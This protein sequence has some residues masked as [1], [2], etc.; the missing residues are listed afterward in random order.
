[1]KES[2]G[3]GQCGGVVSRKN[4]YCSGRSI[5]WSSP[6][7]VI[8]GEAPGDRHLTAL[9][10]AWI[11]MWLVRRLLRLRADDVF[12]ARERKQVTQLGRVEEERGDDVDLVAG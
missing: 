3:F 1:M 9:V 8:H 10:A 2:C 7:D 4:S 5:V 6:S 11:G 12:N